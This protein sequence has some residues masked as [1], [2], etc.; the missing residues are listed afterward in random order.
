MIKTLFPF[1]SSGF[2]RSIIG[3]YPQVRYIITNLSRT[4]IVSQF[5]TYEIN[6]FIKAEFPMLIAEALIQYLI[7]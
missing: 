4:N 2:Y 6:Q 5:I 7:T 3:A 1:I